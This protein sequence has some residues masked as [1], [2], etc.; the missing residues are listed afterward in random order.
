MHNVAR[1]CETDSEPIDTV[2]LFQITHQK[3]L[4]SRVSIFF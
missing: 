3:N 4:A 2:A 1:H